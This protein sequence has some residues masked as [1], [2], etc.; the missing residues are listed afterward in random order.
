MSKNFKPKYTVDLTNVADLSD[1]YVAIATGKLNA[2][3]ITPND[4]ATIFNNQ[5]LQDM[6]EH[7]ARALVIYEDGT[8]EYVTLS[9]IN[10]ASTDLINFIQ[11]VVDSLKPEKKE[12]WYKRLWHKIFP[13]KNKKVADT[14]K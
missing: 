9:V 8:A 3:E 2:S 12:P 10:A 5:I 14:S 1:I 7:D 4:L 13:K 11:E 6:K